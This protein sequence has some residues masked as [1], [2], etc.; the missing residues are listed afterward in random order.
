MLILRDMALGRLPVPEHT[1]VLFA[2]IFNA[3]GHE[4]V[5]IHN[6][7]NQN[8][9]VEGMGFRATAN[10]INLNRDH[11]RAVTV[12]MRGLLDVVNRWR[13]HLHVDNHVT[14]GSDHG[15]VLTW[16]VAEE[17][18]LSEPLDR[19]LG[20]TLPEV[21]EAT[22]EAGH[23][24]G[25]YV[26]LRD[27]TDPSQGFRWLWTSPRLSTDY[28]TLRNRPSILIEMHAHKPFRDRVL[29]NR[30]FM[31]E[32]IRSVDREPGALVAAVVEAEAIT[33]HRGGPDAE[34]SEIVLR[35]RPSGAFEEV[36]WPAARWMVKE[37]MV[38]GAPQL[39][40]D[41]GTYEPIRVP[42]YHGQKTE[43]VATE[44]TWIH[45]P[46]RL[47]ADRTSH[48]RSRLGGSS[49]SGTHGTGGGDHPGF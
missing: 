19:W 2:P 17:P 4:R 34:P 35:W 30:D 33:V 32:L 22:A 11:L 14:N 44:A 12:E 8:G 7:A 23:S 39:Y 24:N 6:R 10:G 20:R 28:F 41:E 21:L 5:S 38:T 31:V 47:A 26:D 16:M 27:P 43:L 29:A 3:D 18:T 45:G 15:W 1:I 9:P 40:F 42:W 46:P 13:P 48:H 49:A 37:S 36:T 25:P